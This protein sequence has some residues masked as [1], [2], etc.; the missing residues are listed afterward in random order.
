[1]RWYEYEAPLTFIQTQLKLT[2][3]MWQAVERP[4][5]EPR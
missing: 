3:V 4:M 2:R 1:M 5:P